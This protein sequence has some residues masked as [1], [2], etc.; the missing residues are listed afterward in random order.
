LKEWPI[1]KKVERIC[2]QCWFSKPQKL[3]IDYINAFQSILGYSKWLIPKCRCVGRRMIG[4]VIWMIWEKK[5]YDVFACKSS[6]KWGQIK[7]QSNANGHIVWIGILL[8]LLM[9]HNL[10]YGSLVCSK[11]WITLFVIY[12]CIQ[13]LLLLPSMCFFYVPYSP[14]G[15]FFPLG[16]YHCYHQWDYTIQ[17]EGVPRTCSTMAIIWLC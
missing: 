3:T 11:C 12:P 1:S 8:M 6:V 4:I 10:F 7:S 17:I 15:I 14:L 9:P 2:L 5:N 16:P 13:S